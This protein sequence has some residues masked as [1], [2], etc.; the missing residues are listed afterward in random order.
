MISLTQIGATALACVVLI[1]IPGP[2]VMFVVGRALTYGRRNAVLS[3]LGNAIGCYL[4][5]VAVACGLGPL[6]E[7]S[8]LLFQII[9]WAGIAYLL[10]LGVQAFRKAGSASEA[11][12]AITG[13]RSGWEAVRTGIIVG[14][15]NP[16]SFVLFTAVVPQFI[17]P[18]AGDTTLQI[19]LLGLIPL[20]IGLVTDTTWA[21]LASR[22][23]IWLA[24]SPRRMT[25]VARGGGVSILGV[26]VSLALSDT[27]P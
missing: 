7:R 13:S 10:W 18:A 21:L 23:R 1:A 9:K 8:D 19:L 16:K 26:G 5:G 20:F 12:P 14:V 27:R 25:T 17:N 11:S 4:A 2:S 15:T 3:V 22:A 6:L 24:R